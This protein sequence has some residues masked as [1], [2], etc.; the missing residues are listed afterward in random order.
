V[1]R[2]RPLAD[3]AVVLAGASAGIGRATAHELSRRGVRGLVLVGRDEATLAELARELAPTPVVT[4]AADVA[5]AEAVEQV[6]AKAVAQ[7]GRLDAWVQLASV[8]TYSTVEQT[9]YADA[10]RVVEVDLL[11]AMYGLKAAVPHVRAAG[12]GVLVSV[13]SVLGRRS[14]PLL[15][16]YCAAKHGIL[17]FTESLR[18]ELAGTGVHVVD[19]LPASINTPFFDNA[20]SGYAGHPRSVPPFYEPEVVAR[21]IAAVLTRPV[22][23]VTVGG[24][25]KGLE[26]LQRM[27]PTLTDSVLRA[28]RVS[29]W[30]T[31][32]RPGEPGDNLRTPTRD[33]H[34][35]G[36]FGREAFPRSAYTEQLGLHPW[37]ARALGAGL[38]AGTIA[39]VRRSVRR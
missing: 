8:A 14:V 33:P 22:R 3:Q 6:A 23:E 10:R 7:F 9:S 38:A 15:S 21:A 39:A 2:V 31:S 29:A 12:G 13:T 16:A 37:R 11:G 19:V 35:R 28:L 27:S 4:A 26:L 25:G 24:A 32:R 17:G 34:V 36:R 20:R 1:T 30:L 18:L 5:D